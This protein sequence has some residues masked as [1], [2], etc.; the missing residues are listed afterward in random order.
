MFKYINIKTDEVICLKDKI[1]NL[2]TMFSYGMEDYVVTN[3][4]LENEEWVMYCV[5]FEVEP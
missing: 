4:K 3:R 5:K 1:E 2:G